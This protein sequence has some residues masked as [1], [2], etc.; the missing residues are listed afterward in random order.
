MTFR[1]SLH[2][3]YIPLRDGASLSDKGNGNSR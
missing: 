3:F 1:A 2:F